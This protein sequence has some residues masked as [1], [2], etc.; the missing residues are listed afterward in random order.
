M[1]T[2]FKIWPL[3]II[4]IFVKLPCEAQDTLV[5]SRPKNRSGIAI[6]MGE[7]ILKEAY[8]RL[9]IDFVFKELPNVRS[10]FTANK[11]DT[12]G[13]FMRLPGLEKTYTNLIMLSIPIAYVDIV[14]YTKYAEFEIEDWQK[15]YTVFNRHCKRKQTA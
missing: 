4:M 12:D 15:P 6:L 7:R 3:L 9:G 13:E 2:Q 14:V 8:N 11:G 1:K 10:L 5:F